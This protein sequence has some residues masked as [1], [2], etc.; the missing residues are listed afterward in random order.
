MKYIV[1]DPAIVLLFTNRFFPFFFVF[2]HVLFTINYTLSALK[3][4]QL[5]LFFLFVS[6]N[7][8]FLFHWHVKRLGSSVF[9][10]LVDDLTRV[11]AIH[12]V[13]Y[14]LE[15]HTH[16]PVQGC[17]MGFPQNWRHGILRHASSQRLA[18]GVWPVVKSEKQKERN[19]SISGNKRIQFS[20]LIPR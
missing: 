19:V 14:R 15:N 11:F 5:V 18:Q 9:G 20:P 6:V 3:I 17:Q 12:T 16:P 2:T 13:S 10:F 8:K 4:S 1:F 7:K